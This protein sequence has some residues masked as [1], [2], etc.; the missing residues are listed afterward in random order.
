MTTNVPVIDWQ[1]TGPV[2][3]TDAAVLAGEQAD[4][5]AAF[6][7]GLNPSLATPQGQ[8]ARS[9]VAAILDKNAM[10]LFL[11]NQFDP[12]T[13]SGTY[14]DALGQMYFL[15]R[16]PAARTEVVGRCYGKTGITIAAGSA[17][18]DTNGYIYYSAADALIPAAGF[19]DVTFLNAEVGPF[20]CPAGNL[21]GIYNRSVIGW[22]S[23]ENLADGTIGRYVE[24]RADFEYRR[25]N[26]V[27]ANANGT[28]SSVYA[29]VF[30]VP[31]VTDV[32]VVDNKTGSI[33]LSGATNYPLDPHSIYVAVVGGGDQAIAEAMFSKV[34]VGCGQIGNT[35]M[36]VQNTEYS[37]PYPVTPTTFN[38]PSALPI[39]FAV[40]IVDGG[41]LP[42]DIDQLIK[43]QIVSYFNGNDS[44]TKERIGG[45]VY[46][47]K[48]FAAVAGAYLG[49]QIVSIFIGTITADQVVVPVGIDQH[50]TLSES[51]ISVIHL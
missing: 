51:D 42:S 50:P 34:D 21:N 39:K 19:V 11:K 3:P 1:D 27:A 20:P 7:G 10:A 43:D 4:I 15:E 31:D 41:G 2:S 22:D 45:S 49:L 33:V 9:I 48:Y 18:I 36:Q 25:K 12:N 35:T 29:A 28:P 30:S 23:V 16:I 47:S 6:G 37:P 5:D 26:S 46:A 13:A 38:R 32:Y 44:A 8:L 24:S 40:T 14:Q 17:A